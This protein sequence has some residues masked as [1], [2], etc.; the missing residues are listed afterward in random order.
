M[1]SEPAGGGVAAGGG[2]CGVVSAV[3]T[4]LSAVVSA[5]APVR[6]GLERVLD[7]EAELLLGKRVALLCNPTS[8]SVD[9]ASNLY[10]ADRANNR[11]LEFDNPFV[12]TASAQTTADRVFGRRRTVSR[13]V[14]HRTGS[15]LSLL[16]H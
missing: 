8:V 15:G 6:S 3:V 13:T 11:I 12:G 1:G 14:L 16:L 4:A 10:I 2:C 5:A 7:D 9:S